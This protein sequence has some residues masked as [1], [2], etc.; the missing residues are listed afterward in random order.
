MVTTI[1]VQIALEIQPLQGLKTEQVTTQRQE[2]LEPVE[3]LTLA[4][5]IATLEQEQRIMETAQG[6]QGHPTA[7]QAVMVQVQVEQVPVQALAEADDKTNLFL[8]FLSCT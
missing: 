3:M 6:I 2:Q 1:I 5:E 8:Y 7:G 4:Q